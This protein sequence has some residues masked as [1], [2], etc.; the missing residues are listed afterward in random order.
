M[1]PI[2]PAAV[3]GSDRTLTCVDAVPSTGAIVGWGGGGDG[4]PLGMRV[5]VG[6][7][8]TVMVNGVTVPAFCS[9]GRAMHPQPARKSM[10]MEKIKKRLGIEIT[11]DLFYLTGMEKT[12]NGPYS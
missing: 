5:S 9:P 8:V 1:I 12:L 3:D 6:G 11:C 7:N 4:V 10:A 2:T